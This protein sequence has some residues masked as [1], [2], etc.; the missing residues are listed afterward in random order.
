M[1]IKE[2]GTL[3]KKKMRK[4][5]SSVF[6]F[7]FSLPYLFYLLPLFGDYACVVLSHL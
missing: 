2:L 5:E 1:H 7:F 4:K 6:P 3:L